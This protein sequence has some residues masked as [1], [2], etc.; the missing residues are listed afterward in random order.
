MS[1]AEAIT[2]FERPRTWV[3]IPV[4]TTGPD[5][6]NESDLVAGLRRG[7]EWAFETMVKTHAPR[8]LAVARRLVRDEED[9]RDVVQDA[10]L[11][12]FRSFSRFKGESRIGTWLHR[13]V[14]NGALMRLRTRRRKPEEPIEP[15]LPTFSADGHHR[16][17]VLEWRPPQEAELERNETRALLQACISRVP[18]GHRTILILRDVE[19]LDTAEA[20]R[21]L[22]ITPAAAKIR[23]HRARQAL[24]TLL[25]PHFASQAPARRTA[26]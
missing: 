11:A 10:F 16:A 3:P 13:I 23:L 4:Q 18:E 26:R 1:R 14:V 20:A 6:L 19:E 5:E 15:L 25:A 17:R 9:A 2:S 21:L 22:G 24:R 7:E 12:A 8:L